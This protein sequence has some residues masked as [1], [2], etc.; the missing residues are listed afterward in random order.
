MT[1][2]YPAVEAAIPCVAWA[3]VSHVQN[4]TRKRPTFTHKCVCVWRLKTVM[5]V[6]SWLRRVTVFWLL[7]WSHILHECVIIGMNRTG[8]IYKTCTLKLCLKHSHSRSFISIKE[9]W[10]LLET[11]LTARQLFLLPFSFN[12]KSADGTIVLCVEHC[13]HN[14]DG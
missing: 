13:K 11:Y 5:G 8:V 9:T 2:V 3:F 10:Q 14:F 4:L 1:S 6:L 7:A 12:E